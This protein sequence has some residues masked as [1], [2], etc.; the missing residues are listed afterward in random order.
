MRGISRVD[1]RET[2]R[3]WAIFR[4]FWLKCAEIAWLAR[5]FAGEAGGEIVIRIN[6]AILPGV[7]RPGISLIITFLR[8]Q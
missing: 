2:A 1:G 4:G 7:Q 8:Y 5:W 3:W 6:K